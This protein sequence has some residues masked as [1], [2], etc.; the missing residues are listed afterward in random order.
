MVQEPLL[1]G[2]WDPAFAVA[3]RLPAPTSIRGGRGEV[4]FEPEVLDLVELPVDRHLPLREQSAD[5]GERLREPTAALVPRDADGVELRLDPSEAEAEVEPLV[6]EVLEGGRA[7]AHEHGVPECEDRDARTDRYRLGRPGEGGESGHRREPG[8]VSIRRVQ[9]VLGH[10]DAGEVEPF[11]P[12]GEP[13]DPAR[14]QPPA[15]RRERRRCDTQAHGSRL[16]VVIDRARRV[17]RYRGG[18]R[19]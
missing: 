9:E 10:P 2:P 19:S 6:R 12:L 18:P 4:R 11:G 16:A 17:T 1:H 8:V 7:L 14:R 13:Q 3:L 5:Q 15:V